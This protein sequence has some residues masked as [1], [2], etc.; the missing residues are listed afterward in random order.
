[1][2]RADLP[3]SQAER[4]HRPIIVLATARVRQDGGS[5]LVNSG[6]SNQRQGAAH[7]VLG[8]TYRGTSLIGNDPSPLGPPQGPR[9]GPTVGSYAGVVYYERSTT[10]M[11]D[12]TP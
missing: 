5:S 1:M 3:R 2:Y 6:I 8:Q 11:P 7:G 4:G 12:E 9:H 10:V